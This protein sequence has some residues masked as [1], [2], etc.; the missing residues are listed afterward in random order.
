MSLKQKIIFRDYKI[1]GEIC[2]VDLRDFDRVRN[3]IAE[4]RPTVTFNLA[5]YGVDRAERDEFTAHQINSRLVEVI[6][7]A[8]ASIKN[9][10]W[11]GQDVINVGT[12]LEYGAI[13]GTLSENSIPNPTTLYGKTKLSGTNLLTQACMRMGIKGLTARLFTVYG[14][15]EHPERLLPSL[16]AAARTGETLQLTAGNQKRDFTFVKDVAEGLLRLGLIETIP[17]D[18]VNLST[19]TLCSVR[20]FV[21]VAATI[22]GIVP[23]QLCFGAINPRFDE[24]EH[25]PVTLAHLRTLLSW[26]PSTNINDGIQR[27]AAF[28]AGYW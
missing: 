4:I 15:G 8:I 23:G 22:L 7:G 20:Q 3:L 6:C 14:P 21:E 13:G 2:V 18:I 17:G 27:T 16:I 19:G 28:E 11:H 24:M 5:G 1:H 10:G 25:E 9:P 26:V 12:A